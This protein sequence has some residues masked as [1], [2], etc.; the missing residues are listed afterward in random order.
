MKYFP[1]L[2]VRGVIVSLLYLPPV[3]KLPICIL[4]GGNNGFL[5][6]LWHISSSHFI[7]RFLFLATQVVVI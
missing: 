7:V 6:L 1:G 4:C 3:A 2:V 5:C